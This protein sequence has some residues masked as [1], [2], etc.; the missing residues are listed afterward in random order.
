[1]SPAIAFN[2]SKKTEFTYVWLALGESFWQLTQTTACMKLCFSS[3]TLPKSS[4][5]VSEL[6]ESERIEEW[7][8][9]SS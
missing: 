9:Y 5:T 3:S 2:W 8:I 1:M 7:N 6:F 4:S